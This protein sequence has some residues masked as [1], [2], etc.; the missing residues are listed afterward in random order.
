MS[1]AVTILPTRRLGNTGLEVPILGLGTGPSGMGLSDRRALRLYHRAMDLGVRYIDTAPGYGRAQRQ[2]ARFLRERP[3]DEELILATKVPED[4]YRGALDSLQRSLDILAVDSVDV[5]YV[6]SLGERDLAG[7]IGPEG[8]LEGLR[9]ARR[10]GW[11]RAIGFTAHNQ[12]GK[13]ARALLEVDVDVVMLAMNYA[14]RQTYDFEGSVL[15][16]AR[17]RG[18][19]VMAM[20]AF[21]GARGMKYSRRRPSAFSAIGQAGHH[22]LALRYCA[23]LDGVAGVV[24]GV[25]TEEELEQIVNWARYLRPLSDEERSLLDVLG[26]EAARRLGEHFGP[27]G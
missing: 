3:K 24:V 2:L 7:V 5:A 12:P 26:A 16:L 9:E 27:V 23:H 1:T 17:E 15:P 13:A 19:G 21:G 18:L 8:S 10:R 25:F 14:D 22:E 4:T 20:K 11:V 6:H